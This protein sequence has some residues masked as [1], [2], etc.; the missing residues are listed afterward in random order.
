[1]LK[2][3]NLLF[4]L[5]S[6]VKYNKVHIC[7]SKCL[8]KF[9]LM[10]WDKWKH[11]FLLCYLPIKV[12]CK[13][14]HICENLHLR[15]CWM[16]LDRIIHIYVKLDLR[17]F[18]L[19][20]SKQQHKLFLIIFHTHYQWQWDNHLCTFPNIRKCHCNRVKHIVCK[21]DLQINCSNI[22]SLIHMCECWGR[23]IDYLCKLP[24]NCVLTNLQK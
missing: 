2:N 3:T 7:L 22:G 14:E 16:K 5:Q 8:H 15:K 19:Y 4:H 11:I 17:K 10:N 21:M 20:N 24:N 13:K 18:H 23:H 9:S 1:M 6:M 12:K